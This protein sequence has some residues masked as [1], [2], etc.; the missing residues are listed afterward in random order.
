MS[1]TNINFNGL[2]FLT[3]NNLVSPDFTGLSLLTG[4]SLPLTI[5]Q[6]VDVINE[7]V[8]DTENSDRIQKI[9]DFIE[10]CLHGA[11]LQEVQQDLDRLKKDVTYRVTTRPYGIHDDVMQYLSGCGT[12]IFD[13]KNPYGYTVKIKLSG[14]NNYNTL[15]K[16][17]LRSDE[18]ITR[19][20]YQKIVNSSDEFLSVFG[21]RDGGRSKGERSKRGRGKG[22][23]SKRGRGKGGKSKRGKSRSKTKRRS[24]GGRK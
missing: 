22:G 7:D 11:I 14:N 23:K 13:Q 8:E 20:E 6:H 4:I 17:Y 9:N 12:W 16:Q 21:L 24:K 3:G 10:K 1:E 5:R 18:T 19:P 15:N 2:S